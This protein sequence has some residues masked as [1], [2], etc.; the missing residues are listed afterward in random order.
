MGCLEAYLTF[1]H[2]LAVVLIGWLLVLNVTRPGKSRKPPEREI[3]IHHHY[4]HFK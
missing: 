4:I 1:E 2:F 3:T